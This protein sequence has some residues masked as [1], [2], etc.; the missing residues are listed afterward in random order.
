MER[1]DWLEEVV[2]KPLQRYREEGEGNTCQLAIGS[3]MD[4]VLASSFKYQKIEIDD[5]FRKLVVN[6]F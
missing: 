5:S 2:K 3:A 1:S 4:S 6:S